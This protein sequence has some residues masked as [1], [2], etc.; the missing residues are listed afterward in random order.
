VSAPTWVLNEGDC[1]DPV[2]GLASL[3]DK[4]VDH[5]ITDPP[6]SERVHRRLGKEGRSDGVA[7]REELSFT[8]LTT[9][10]V[11]GVSSAVARAC[12]RWCL[13]FCDEL[14]FGVWV[15]GLEGAG[16]QY[17]RKGTW[18]K[19]CP[20]PQMSGDRP[21]TGTEEIVV[22]HAPRESGRTKWNGGGRTAV[23]SANPQE[24][25]A[26]REHPAQKPISLI[27][28]LIADF[29][30]PGD[31]ILDPF[32]GSGTTGVAAIRLGRNF[33]GWERDPKYAAIARKR[34][35]AAREQLGLQGVA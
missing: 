9:E 21:A 32:A 27:E 8:H 4:S 6:Y 18:V 26:A 20:M 13:V 34:L 3:A 29:T 15:D 22:A 33:I 31:T 7:S 35:G 25:L 17:V 30:D 14:S 24:N 2:T 19:L 12:R 10:T 5:V 23:Y 16:C 28:K 1:L 11:D